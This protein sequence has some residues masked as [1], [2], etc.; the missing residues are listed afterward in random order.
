MNHIFR[1]S[2]VRGGTIEAWTTT[3]VFPVG[4]ETFNVFIEFRIVEFPREEVRFRVWTGN[5]V[6]IQTFG[7]ECRKRGGSPFLNS[8]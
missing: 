1:K 3:L 5:Y 7:E 6:K 2:E 8:E 4:I